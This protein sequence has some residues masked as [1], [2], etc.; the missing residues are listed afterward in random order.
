MAEEAA[1]AAASATKEQRAAS[2][3]A[4][5]TQY[6]ERVKAQR[7][8]PN[9][10]RDSEEERLPIVDE[11]T[12]FKCTCLSEVELQGLVQVVD[13]TTKASFAG[14]D[15]CPA[16]RKGRPTNRQRLVLLLSDASPRSR[17]E[18]ILLAHQLKQ[19]WEDILIGSIDKEL[20]TLKNRML[21]ERPDVAEEPSDKARFSGR[22]ATASLQSHGSTTPPEDVPPSAA[23]AF[24]PSVPG[25][26]A[27][28]TL[29]VRD[30]ADGRV[31]R[32]TPTPSTQI[33]QELP[34]SFADSK[35]SLSASFEAKRRRKR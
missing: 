31:R 20:V 2:F 21:S 5:I 23:R 15:G 34:A 16:Q 7:E 11:R 29:R 33:R 6:L 28:K 30:K 10:R 8:E 24:L 14:E 1:R 9:E 27:N 35:S 12:G 17:H 19:T 13:Q 4:V 22:P 3:A 25:S 32:Q 18:A 26:P